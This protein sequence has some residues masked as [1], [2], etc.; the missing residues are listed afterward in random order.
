[1][2]R[3][4]NLQKYCGY[5]IGRDFMNDTME[6]NKTKGLQEFLAEDSSLMERMTYA[7]FQSKKAAP[8]NTDD[9]L[10]DVYK[11][12]CDALENL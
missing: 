4:Y 1:M 2:E 12:Y 11:A 9:P 7:E 5:N 6:K 8:D 10:P 3:W